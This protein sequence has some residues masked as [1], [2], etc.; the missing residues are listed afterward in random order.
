MRPAPAARAVAI[1]Q[2]MTGR[3]QSGCS[4]FGTEERMRVP[5]PAAR[6]TMTG[7]ATA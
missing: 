7:A 5:C 4:S 1:V 2:A 3:P 6:M